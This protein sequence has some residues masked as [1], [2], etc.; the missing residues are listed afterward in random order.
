MSPPRF[1]AQFQKSSTLLARL[2]AVTLMSIAG[3]TLAQSAGNKAAAEA[4]FEQGQQLMQ[5][6]DFRQACLKFEASQKLD[7]G[8]GT[9][10]YLADCYE[11][12]GRTASAWATFKEAASMAGAQGQENRQKL[13]TQRARAL[14]PN[15]V[16]LTVDVAAGDESIVGFEVRN[17]GIVIPSAQ[18]ATPFPIDPGAHRIEASAP[19][20]KTHTES[21]NAARGQV[22]VSIPVLTDLPPNAPPTE[23]VTPVSTGQ[24]TS[25][26]AMTAAPV[27]ATADSTSD[28][29]KTQRTLAY[30][31]GGLGIVGV[32][33]GTYFGIRALA[34]NS[35]SKDNCTPDPN[36]CTDTGYNQRQDALKQARVSTVAFSAGGA[37]LATAAILYFTAKPSHN[38]VTAQAQISSQGA[39]LNLQT[40]W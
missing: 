28:H 10:L 38:Q 27:P 24:S 35:S 6:G 12:I 15:L 33:L 20:K 8:I 4:A 26:L 2:C 23:G 17:D 7:Q 1:E 31:A 37:L 9:L 29:G 40:N 13:A 39:L 11:K 19:G 5:A 14:E 34:N 36:L 18:F 25:P 16:K 22:H 21:I 32:G 3:P 30:V